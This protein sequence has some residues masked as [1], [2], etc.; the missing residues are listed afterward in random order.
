MDSSYN[1]R[2]SQPYT[3]GSAPASLPLVSVYSLRAILAVTVLTNVF[4]GFVV[5]AI[6]WSRLEA[7]DKA[8]T[9]II[10]GAVVFLAIA[11]GIALVPGASA[12]LLLANIAGGYYLK[13]QTEEDI[14]ADANT[15]QVEYANA[16]GAVGI[17]LACI[18]VL[19]VVVVAPSAV[20]PHNS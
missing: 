18:V 9:H 12:G 4:S 8:R 15:K 13:K 14:A 6:N 11:L 5:S 10:I 1:F 17:G 2:N 16:W 3:P 20:L 19:V 7:A